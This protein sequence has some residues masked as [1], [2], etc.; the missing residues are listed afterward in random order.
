MNLNAFTAHTKVGGSMLDIL[1]IKPERQAAA[2]AVWVHALKG[3][4]LTAGRVS[5]HAG[6]RATD[7]P[8]AILRSKTLASHGCGAPAIC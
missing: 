7:P 5:P 2:R 1:A 3:E 4:A 8:R 6:L